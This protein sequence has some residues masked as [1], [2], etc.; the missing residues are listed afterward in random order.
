MLTSQTK[1]KRKKQEK[2]KEYNVDLIVVTSSTAARLPHL[3]G[4]GPTQMHFES[5]LKSLSFV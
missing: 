2:E 1:R 3:R 4:W 5:D